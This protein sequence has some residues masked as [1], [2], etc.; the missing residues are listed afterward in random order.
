MKDLALLVA[1]KNM[2]FAMRGILARP[3]ALKI[4][5]IE[6]E[7]KPH[8]GR[9]GGVRT[10]GPEIMALLRDQFRHGIVMLDWEGSGTDVNS[11]HALQQELDERLSKFWD[12][13]ARAI[14]ID[15]ELDAWI[16]GSDNVMGEVLDWGEEKPIRE[17]L[18]EQG[19]EFDPARKPLRPKEALE[20]LMIH[21]G[22]PRSSALYRKV[23]TRISLTRCADPGFTRL[24]F[25]LQKWFPA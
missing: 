5:A 15:P 7:I 23:T 9:D 18:A 24:K 6:Y 19:F 17:W 25:F 4:Q 2:D 3:E 10:T 1:D 16:W 21:L 13:R 8:A 12:D 11:V 20:T 22:E 14:V